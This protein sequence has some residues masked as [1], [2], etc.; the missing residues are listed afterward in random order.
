[1][2]FICSYCGAKIRPDNDKACDGNRYAVSDGMCN[3]CS[4]VALSDLDLTVE[5]VRARSL[6]MVPACQRSAGL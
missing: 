5:Q 3:R 4:L 2:I 1:M 6:A